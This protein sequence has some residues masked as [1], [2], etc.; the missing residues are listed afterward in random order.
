MNSIP[1]EQTSQTATGAIA[2]AVGAAM[3][4]GQPAWPER[5]TP[6]YTVVQIAPSYSQF[7]EQVMTKSKQPSHIDFAR[8]VAAIYASVSERQ[9]RLGAEYEAAIFDDLDG[10]YEA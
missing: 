4:A 10:L 6:S 7:S 8:D 1:N 9:E 5:E 2:F 3:A